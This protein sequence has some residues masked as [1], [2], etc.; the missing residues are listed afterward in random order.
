MTRLFVQF[1]DWKLIG[2]ITL[3]PADALKMPTAPK[4]PGVYRFWIETGPGRPRVYIG[5]TDNIA[6]RMYQYA[7]P[8]RSQ[9]TNA[10][11]NAEL[12][13]LLRH[14]SR[15]SLWIVTEAFVRLDAM[16][17]LEQVDLDRKTSRLIVENAALAAARVENVA[18][19]GDPD[20]RPIILNLPGRGEAAW[21]A[22]TDEEA[23]PPDGSAR[24]SNRR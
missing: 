4:R 5:E 9:K 21:E 11:V 1:D 18:E 22:P 8:S 16:E 10:R 12:L 7:R 2:N 3:D 24:P 15:V 14:G 20:E 19:L 6:R 23:G 13:R 17:E